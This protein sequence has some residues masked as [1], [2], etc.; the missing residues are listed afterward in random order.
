MLTPPE[1]SD[2][3]LAQLSFSVSLISGSFLFLNQLEQNQLVAPPPPRAPPL[4][5]LP[6]CPAHPA[7]PRPFIKYKEELP[8]RVTSGLHV[9]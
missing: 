3:R 1:Q 7:L 2:P 5:P 6:P 4:L 9:F 8:E